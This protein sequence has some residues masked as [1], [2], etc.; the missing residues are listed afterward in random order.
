MDENIKYINLK[1]DELPDHIRVH[2]GTFTAIYVNNVEPIE[3]QLEEAKQEILRL[4]IEL[5][6]AKNKLYD[7]NRT[8]N[9]MRDDEFNTVHFDGDR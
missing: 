5:R 7:K 3:E 9:R 6:K 1:V 4:K 2:K 8:I